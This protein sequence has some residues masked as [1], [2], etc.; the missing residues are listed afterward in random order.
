MD[1][2][3][4]EWLAKRILHLRAELNLTQDELARMS[5][6]HRN[7]IALIERLERDP[8]ISTVGKILAGSGMSPVEFFAPLDKPL[9][10]VRPRPPKRKGRR[11]PRIDI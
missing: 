4:Q 6:L 1:I 3:F 11:G 2:D 8:R 5:G 10:P 7:E 9:K